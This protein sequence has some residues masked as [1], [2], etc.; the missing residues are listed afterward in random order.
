MIEIWVPGLDPADDPMLAEVEGA[1][2]KLKE[3]PAEVLGWSI[4]DAL[5]GD[6]KG[7]RKRMR[8]WAA[9]VGI[10]CDTVRRTDAPVLW[11]LYQDGWRTVGM[12]SNMPSLETSEIVDG[13][14]SMLAQYDETILVD[15]G[16]KLH[17]AS[18]SESWAALRAFPRAGDGNEFVYA[19][20]LRRAKHGESAEA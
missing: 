12:P 9:K 2:S 8:A 1:C 20:L 14:E 7:A 15:F 4:E 13:R 6:I 19:D 16:R 3:I 10:T 11:T 18:S 5:L 17:Y